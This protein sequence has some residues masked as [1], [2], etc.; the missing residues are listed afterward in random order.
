VTVPD[1]TGNQRR[2]ALD[3][4]LDPSTAPESASALETAG[5]HSGWVTETVRDPYL[6]LSAAADATSTMSLGTGVA[7]AFARSPMT[8]ALCAHDVQRRSGGRL[9]L[10]LGSQVRAHIT[11]RFSMPWSHPAPRMREYVL[12]LRAIWSS[13][14][15][16]SPLEF[17]GHFYTHT[18]MTPFF[19]P[20]PTG[21]PAP[22]ILLGGVGAQMTAVAGEVA[23]GLICG[24]LTSALS[25]REQALVSLERGLA[26]RD[27]APA[28]FEICVMPL[29]V[30]G[31][32]EAATARVAAAT[33]ARIAFY[34]STPAYRHV[35]DL[36]GWGA[37]HERLHALSRDGAW[38]AMADLVDDEVLA[39][40]AVVAEP[41]GVVA[42]V[43]RRFGAQAQRA[44]LHSAADLD[45]P[46]WQAVV[47]ASTPP[48][49]VKD[50]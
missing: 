23:D 10:G 29:V 12:A 41:D 38:S 27:T 18:L 46:T 11:R 37:L 48:A 31:P 8:T 42:E 22:P 24:P 4:V 25:F 39:T 14:I 2:L 43:E 17:E 16:G 32:D 6:Y 1:R 45:L 20:G 49:L 13:W 34:G 47:S 40:F 5:F 21:F 36:H 44:I 28:A 19:N 35:F 3:S 33:R 26:R 30:S 50:H 7:I 15:D 9:K